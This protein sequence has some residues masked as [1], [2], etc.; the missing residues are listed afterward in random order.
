[1]DGWLNSALRI[2]ITINQILTSGIAITAFSLL[3]Y[4]LTFNLRDRV[5]RAF[6]LI[7]ICLVV[8]FSADSFGSTAQTNAAI[9]FW[10]N[11]QWVAIIFLPSAYLNFSDALLATTGK[12]SRWRR[13]W[14]IR[15]TGLLALVFL[16]MLVKGSFVGP[17]LTENTIVPHSQPT[18]LTEAF[19]IF[20]LLVMAMAWFNFIRAYKRT[21]THTS[22]RRMLYLTLAALGPAVGSFPFLLYGSAFAINIPV[23][24]WFIAIGANVIL[25]VS[26]IAMAYSVAFFGVPWPD[27]LVKSRLF[28]WLLR[29]PVTASL[30]L[31]VVTVVRRVGVIYGNPYIA[32]VP[33]SM[34]VVILLSEFLITILY[35]YIESWLF[36]GNDVQEL[37]TLRSWEEKLI[38]R[39]DLN[40]FLEMVLASVCDRLQAKGAYLAALNSDGLE[41]VSETG[42]SKVSTEKLQALDGFVRGNEVSGVTSWRDDRLFPVMNG[43][44]QGEPV[45]VGYIG[46]LGFADREDLDSEDI[47]ALQLLG[48]RAALALKDREAQEQI[49]RSLE[50]MTPQVDMIQQLRAAGRYDRNGLMAEEEAFHQQT[51]LAQWIKDALTHYWGGPRLSESPLMQ[52]TIVKEALQDHDNNPQNALRSVLKTAIEQMRPEG[53]RKF[54][55]EWLLYNILDLKFMEGKR[56]REIARRL[57]I[58]EADLYRKQRVAVE[59]IAN[60]IVQLEVKAMDSKRN[61]GVG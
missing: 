61:N 32:L 50:S 27:R 58:S 36:F 29:G 8:L 15:V 18:F 49:F 30:T 21:L 54:T 48:H 12:P 55:S 17:V 31:A 4:A 11:M 28:K 59:A 16:V 25:T 45:V 1:M 44:G 22:H 26:L 20:Y 13:K 2:L 9:G 37:E 23:I 5:A 51:E 57:A 38:T 19:T 24:F 53:E 56:V 7:L 43:N 42:T 40:Q 41:I 3:L 47:S 52:L 10:L 6:A 35:P 34:A 39:S 14:A 46:I 33:I 60:N